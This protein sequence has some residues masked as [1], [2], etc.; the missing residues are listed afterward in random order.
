MSGSNGSNPGDALH[1]EDSPLRMTVHSLPAAQVDEAARRTARGRAKMLLVLLVCALPVIASYITYYVVRPDGRSNYSELIQPSRAAPA[2]LGLSDL[3]G[4]AIS[5]Q[6]LRGQ[7]LLLVVAPGAC[8]EA[9]ERM[10]WLQRQL[11]E[12]LGRDKDRVDK[13]WLIPDAGVPSA[14]TLQAIAQGGPATALRADPAALGR[15][16]G[17]SAPW[18]SSQQIYIVDPMGDWMM[19]SPANPEPA[20]LKRDLEKLLRASAGWDTPGR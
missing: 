3:Q 14:R 5:T 17:R 11:R 15:W 4:A 20:K 10:L 16:L 9:C 2:D 18:G 12:T 19:R 6:S 13:V 8:D 1:A 7:W